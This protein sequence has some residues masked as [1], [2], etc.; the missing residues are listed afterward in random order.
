MTVNS[1]SDPLMKILRSLTHLS[2]VWEI[3]AVSSEIETHVRLL[4]SHVRH[5]CEI[6]LFR[7]N[8]W[9]RQRSLQRHSFPWWRRSS[10]APWTL[11]CP[12]VTSWCLSCEIKALLRRVTTSPL[13]PLHFLS[14]MCVCLTFSPIRPEWMKP[15]E[16]QFSNSQIF[17]TQKDRSTHAWPKNWTACANSL[18]AFSWR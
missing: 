15:K 2:T 18:P 5:T 6:I 9:D 3:A 14:L 7:R 11:Y 8:I 10:Q 13:S 17:T 12:S 4:E 1:S 16:V